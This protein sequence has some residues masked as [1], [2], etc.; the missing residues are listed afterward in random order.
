LNEALLLQL[1]AQLLK[2]NDFA[3]VTLIEEPEMKMI[4]RR[5]FQRAQNRALAVPILRGDEEAAITMIGRNL[6]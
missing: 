1:D 6:N 3:V 2:R 5:R 4:S